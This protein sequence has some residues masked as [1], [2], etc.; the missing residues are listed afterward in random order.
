METKII[1]LT[2]INFYW[3]LVYFLFVIS[4]TE[5]C[6]VPLLTYQAKQ[7]SSEVYTSI[8]RCMVSLWL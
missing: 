5:L 2:E 6:D 7:N 4:L 1:V 3:W 8:E